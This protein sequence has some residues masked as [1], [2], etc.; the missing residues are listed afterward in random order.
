M[1]VGALAYDSVPLGQIGTLDTFDPVFQSMANDKGGMIYHMLRWVMGDQKFDK[2][3]RTLF[4]TMWASR[5]GSRIC[6]K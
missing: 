3:M 6:R 5:W 4:Q 1:A 2:A